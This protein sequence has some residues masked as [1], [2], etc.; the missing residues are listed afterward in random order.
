MVRCDWSG[1][2]SIQKEEEEQITLKVLEKA[3]KI[4]QVVPLGTKIL[5]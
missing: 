2:G 4:H 5:L 3:I 1:V